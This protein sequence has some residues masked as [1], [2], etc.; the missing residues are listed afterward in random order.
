MSVYRAAK[1]I[2]MVVGM[3]VKEPPMT[4][5][6][7]VPKSVCVNVLMPATKSSV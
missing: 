1:M 2:E 7:R 4:A 5:G 3:K 6:K